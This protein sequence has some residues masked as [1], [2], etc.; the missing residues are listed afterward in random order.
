MPQ[1]TRGYSVSEVARSLQLH[2]QT[3]REA[4]ARKELRARRLRPGNPRS[5]YLVTHDAL[6]KWLAR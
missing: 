1:P 3:I 2:P 4:I 5:K 6:E